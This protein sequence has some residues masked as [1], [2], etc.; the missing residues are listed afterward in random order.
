MHVIEVA[1][2][3]ENGGFSDPDG[4][5]SAALGGAQLALVRPDRVVS[6][7]S[8]QASVVVIRDYARDVLGMPVAHL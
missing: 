6:F 2:S 5:V 1:H 8:A 4:L 3:P 7:T